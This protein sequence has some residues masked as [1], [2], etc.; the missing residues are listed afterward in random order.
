MSFAE[1]YLEQTA[2]VIDALDAAAIEAVASG[3]ADRRGRGG[4][5]FILGVGGS[6]GHAGHAVNDFRKLCAFEAYAPTDNVSELTARTND[7]GW[8][9]T[10]SAWLEGSRVRADDAVLVF[11]VGGG[12]AERGVSAN[13]VRAVDAASAAGAGIYGIV[14]RDGGH[15]ARVADACVVIPPLYPEHLTPHTEA[16]CAVVWH[17]LVSHPALKAAETKWEAVAPA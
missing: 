4:R 14:G 17:L 16:L 11:S 3:L 2:R 7:E 8:D 5:L 6:A 1:R 9:T 13:L 12:D 15:T 10:F